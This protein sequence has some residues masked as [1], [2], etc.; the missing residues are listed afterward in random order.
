MKHRHL[1]SVLLLVLCTAGL[2]CACGNSKSTPQTLYLELA[3]LT[4]EEASLAQLMGTERLEYLY[5]FAVDDAAQS[6]HLQMYHLVN[7]KWEPTEQHSS[8]ALSGTTGRILLEIE[9]FADGV[10]RFAVQ[11]GAPGEKPNSFSSEKH[12]PPESADEED[13]LALGYSRLATRLSGQKAV[14]YE[15]EIPVAIQLYSKQ[16]AVSSPNLEDFAHPENFDVSHGE[17]VYAITI[18]FSQNP[19]S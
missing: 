7:G 6:L 8:M 18:L 9:D 16:N 2:L 15:E 5:N 3:Q 17:E 12:L 4:E 1:F 19:L 14:V 11:S 10:R 13:L